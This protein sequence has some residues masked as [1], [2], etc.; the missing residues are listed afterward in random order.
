MKKFV[1]KLNLNYKINIKMFCSESH[2]RKI[3]FYS[4]AIFK[5]N[6]VIFNFLIRYHVKFF[7]SADLF[8]K[9]PVTS[10]D[11]NASE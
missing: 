3:K 8:S 9:T 6:H 11:V 4:Y 10:T 5:Q 2:T 1:L 7:H